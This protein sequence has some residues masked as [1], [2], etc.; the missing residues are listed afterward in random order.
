MG[1]HGYFWH[2]FYVYRL[3]SGNLQHSYWKWPIYSWF[4]YWR[5]W[6]SIAMLV[7]QRLHL[8]WHVSSF[9]SIPE[10][11]NPAESYGLSSREPYCWMAINQKLQ[12]PE[13]T[14]T[15]PEVIAGIAGIVSLFPHQNPILFCPS[16]HS[17][18]IH[19]SPAFPAIHPSCF[20]TKPT[21]H[22]PAALE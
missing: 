21:N 5:C 4:T 10:T 14:Q 9:H 1:N 15:A 2:L 3:P 6:F 19:P 11:W 20:T 8:I 18:P 16:T 7:Y 12:Q 17:Q 13:T 22:L